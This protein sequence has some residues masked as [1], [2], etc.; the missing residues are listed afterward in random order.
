MVSNN[1]AFDWL[2]F[3]VKPDATLSTLMGW[4]VKVVMWK[5]VVV[6]NRLVGQQQSSDDNNDDRTL[7]MKTTAKYPNVNLN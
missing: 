7:H 2:N 5:L 1:T 6:V 3:F 4:S